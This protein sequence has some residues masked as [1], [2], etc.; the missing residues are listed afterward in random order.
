MN[1]LDLW[2]IL[3]KLNWQEW[4]PLLMAIYQIVEDGGFD[5]E[6]KPQ[7]IVA[8]HEAIDQM[9]FPPKL[10]EIRKTWAEGIVEDIFWHMKK[11]PDLPL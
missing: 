10:T 6:D 8:V 7:A 9:G 3:M 4:L 2:K 5:Y 1:P 11:H